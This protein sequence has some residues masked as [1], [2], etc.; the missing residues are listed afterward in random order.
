MIVCGIGS[1]AASGSSKG[2]R[3]ERHGFSKQS[4]ATAR[5]PPIQSKIHHQGAEGTEKN[6]RGLI[7]SRHFFTRFLSD[8]SVCVCASG[9]AG[10]CKAV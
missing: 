3:R 1:M 6:I 8:E 2:S 7:L 5:Y 4:R 10:S 9:G